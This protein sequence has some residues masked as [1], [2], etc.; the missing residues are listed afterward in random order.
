MKQLLSMSESEG[1][2]VSM[3]VCSNFLV[4]GT[5]NGYVKMFDLSR[6]SVNTAT[7]C[8]ALSAPVV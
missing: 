6:R 1:E 2:P 8:V 7:P 5:S 4:V 3:D